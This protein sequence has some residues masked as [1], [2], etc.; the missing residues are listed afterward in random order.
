MAP[1]EFIVLNHGKTV[2]NVSLYTKIGEMGS[3]KI[4]LL[5]L[6]E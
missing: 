2:F 6:I 4:T 5:L 3:K 1:S